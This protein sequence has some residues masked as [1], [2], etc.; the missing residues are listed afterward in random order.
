MASNYKTLKLACYAANVTMSVVGN[1][2]PLLFV[3]FRELYGISYS[4]LGLL[5]LINF[6]TQLAID[7]IFSFFSY[8]FNIEKVVRLAPVFAFTGLLI[9]AAWPLL[10]PSSAYVGIVIG[11]LIFALSGGLCEVLISPVIAAIPS[12]DPDRE[13][14]KLHSVYAWGVVPVIVLTTLFLLVFKSE[15]WHWLIFLYMLVPLASSVLFAVS[16]IP[17][18]KTPERVSGALRFLKNR[19]LWM[20]VAAIFLGGAAECAMSQWASSYLEK[21]IRLPKV[22]GDVLGVALFALMLGLGRSLYAKFGKKLYRVLILGALGATVCYL[23]AAF[24]LS[25]AVALAACALTGLC[26]SMLW[27]GSL[28]V[29]SERFPE[30]GVFI[31][32]MMAAGGDL[33]ASAVPQLIGI[34]TDTALGNP[35]LNS[36]ATDIGISPEQF[37]M[38]LGMLI[39][40]LFPLISVPIFVRLA[41]KARDS[42]AKNALSQK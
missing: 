19:E 32:A 42:Q 29:S 12:D 11:T 4:L 1:I 39:G 21:A 28:I 16:E 9:Y 33:G 40:A 36:L 7:L 17:P 25:P 6:G 2:S 30:S 14:S 41:G 37:G 3:T 18:M 23:A 27:P 34:V 35:S 26:V 31:Y 38:K 10:W 22:W 20:C 13:M 5:I 8:K 24:T 15:N